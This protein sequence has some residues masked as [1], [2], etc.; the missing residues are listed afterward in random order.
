MYLTTK[1]Q[2]AICSLVDLVTNSNG[3]TVSLKDIS[4]RQNI[5]V[6]YLEQLFARLRRAKIVR[7]IRGPGGG[8]L[9]NQNPNLI[10]INQ[11]FNS[12]GE[13]ITLPTDKGNFFREFETSIKSF[14]NKTLAQVI[15]SL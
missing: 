3:R 5:S 7:S 10:T 14:L 2:Y 6:D 15:E 1:G 11:I 9:L 8:Y 13:Q 12:V 4:R